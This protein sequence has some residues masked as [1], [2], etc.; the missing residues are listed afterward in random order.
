MRV[1]NEVME[2]NPEIEI[3]LRFY[4]V[5]AE[6]RLGELVKKFEHV[7]KHIVFVSKL[8]NM[9]FAKEIS[10]ANLLLLFNDFSVLG[11][12]IFDYLAVRRH[13][14]LCFENDEEGNA[15]KDEFF[16]LSEEMETSNSLQADLIGRTGAGTVVKDAKHLAKVLVEKSGELKE[17]GSVKCDS[18]GIDEYSRVAQVER[19]AELIEKTK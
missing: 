19:L 11:T 12:K 10:T 3:E 9:E 6:G 8:P 18:V 1:C 13:V 7:G 14:I 15:L 17:F 5:N 2:K 4:G 16:H